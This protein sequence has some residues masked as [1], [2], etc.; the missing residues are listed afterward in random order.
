MRFGVHTFQLEKIIPTDSPA[1][2]IV[3][4]VMNHNPANIVRELHG[5]GFQLAELSLD[6]QMFLPHTFDTHVIDDLLLAKEETG[7]S[8]TVHL[9][10]WSIEPSTPQNHIRVASVQA[11]VEAIQATIPLDPETYVLHATGALASEFY[12]MD[13]PALVKQFAL[14]QFEN[15]S[16]AS[17][18]ALLRKTGID[19]RKIAAETIEFPFEK[20]LALAEEFDLS[21]C[22]DTGHVLVGFSGPIDLF[23]ALDAC[24]PRLGEIH[25]H[26]GPWQGPQRII[27][28]DKDH[29]AL[30]QG[31]LDIPRFFSRLKKAKY[32]GPI[33]F[34]LTLAEALQSL[35]IIRQTNP[36]VL[37]GFF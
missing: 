37:H 3:S 34:E 22:L 8:Y 10:L 21:I 25:L 11:L 2:E 17:I 7:M 1:E 26:D 14:Q 31:D 30:G 4:N 29:Q 15:R 19:S 36:D 18:E 5:H 27:G 35:A 24:L 12:R 20:T 16:R 6:L 28:Y 32:N 13:A 9:P 23:D 33:I